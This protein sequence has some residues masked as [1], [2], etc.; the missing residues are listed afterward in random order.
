[1]VYWNKCLDSGAVP[2]ASTRFL[3]AL[4]EGHAIEWGRSSFDRH[5]KSILLPSMIPLRN[6]SKN[7]NGKVINFP[8][9]KKSNATM[10]MAA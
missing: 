10:L 1:M 2:D 6:G 4:N 5:I 9:S 7:I 3:M 8:V